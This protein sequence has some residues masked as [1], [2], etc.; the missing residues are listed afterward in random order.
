MHHLLETRL[1]LEQAEY[2]RVAL[3]ETAR[4]LE[5]Q[6]ILAHM[7]TL[8]TMDTCKAHWHQKQ[9][10]RHHDR[11]KHLAQLHRAAL[12][13]LRH[14]TVLLSQQ[15]AN[16][17]TTV[18]ALQAKIDRNPAFAWTSHH[19]KDTL[20]ALYDAKQAQVLG[21]EQAMV[22]NTLHVKVSGLEDKFQWLS[23]SI[24]MKYQ[25]Y[26]D[27]LEALEAEGEEAHR[28]EEEAGGVGASQ[29]QAGSREVLFAT[30]SGATPPY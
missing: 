20:V 15:C 26:N 5:E 19:T 17:F 23:D 16:D 3:K 11:T 27:H 8:H 9:Q 28:R 21:Q 10:Q 25:T 14:T 4:D 18:L 22:N 2:D 13:K 1:A 12:G 7:S 29:E 24:R 6:Q 30:Q